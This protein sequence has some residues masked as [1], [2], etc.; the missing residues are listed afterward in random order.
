MTDAKKNNPGGRPSKFR[1]KSTKPTTLSLTDDAK[2]ILAD[3]A[4]AAGTSR[5]DVVEAL[6]RTYCSPGRLVGDRGEA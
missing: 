1:G 5:S 2:A 3:T 6:I 4:R